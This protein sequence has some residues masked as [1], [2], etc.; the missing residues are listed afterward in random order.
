MAPKETDQTQNYKKVRS[1]LHGNKGRESLHVFS[2]IVSVC[3]VLQQ[4]TF[5]DGQHI[6]R[7]TATLDSLLPEKNV[8]SPQFKIIWD[9]EQGMLDS[10]PT[11][12]SGQDTPE[13]SFSTAA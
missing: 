2:K 6:S 3:P 13:K 7:Q 11:T 10:F 12:F 4:R 9:T 8:F 1:V 5:C